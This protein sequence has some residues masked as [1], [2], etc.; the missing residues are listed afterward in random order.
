MN[1]EETVTIKKAELR[2]ITSKLSEA[3]KI[4]RELNQ[5]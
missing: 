3:L 4:V 1:S 5:K 2:E